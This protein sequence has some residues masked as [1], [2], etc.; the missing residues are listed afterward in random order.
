MSIT[1]K[2]KQQQY[3]QCSSRVVFDGERSGS[4]GTCGSSKAPEMRAT[5]PTL[6]AEYDEA[7]VAM[8]APLADIWDTLE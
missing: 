2:K 4:G 1:A 8:A 5:D 6:R 7:I 3:A